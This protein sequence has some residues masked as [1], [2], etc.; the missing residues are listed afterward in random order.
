MD[1]WGQWIEDHEYYELE[2][3]GIFEHVRNNN[4][5][6]KTLQVSERGANW[7]WEA[8][9]KCLGENIS[10]RRLEIYDHMANFQKFAT[11]QSFYIGLCRNRSIESLMIRCYHET[12]NN[13]ALHI[14]ATNHLFAILEPLLESNTNIQSLYIDYERDDVVEGIADVI[15]AC[16][17]LKSIAF[18]FS[19][20]P[21]KFIPN[22]ASWE[23]IVEAIIR[24]PGLLHVSFANC[25]LSMKSCRCI[26][27]VLSHYSSEIKSLVLQNI[28]FT[29]DINIS[30]IANGLAN[31]SS[32]KCLHLSLTSNAISYFLASITSSLRLETVKLRSTDGTHGAESIA[33]LQQMPL[34]KSISLI[35]KEHIDPVTCR[36]ICAIVLSP[37][38][39]VRKLFIPITNDETIED[40]STYL[41]V[42]TSLKDICLPCWDRVSA[43]TLC[44][45]FRAMHTLRLEKMDLSC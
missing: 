22:C 23:S 1:E 4:P 27:N 17:S 36:E 16:P 25:P 30:I 21:H 37:S 41:A 20:Y 3:E 33:A 13:P 44:L 18:D 43:A 9:G 6:I 42:A 8:A 26:A 14:Y 7:D 12:C 40:L 28:K 10:I 39:T 5:A 45:L 19:S 2:K 38:S 32:V 31:N 35:G 29:N 15:E 24:K 11:R 34:L